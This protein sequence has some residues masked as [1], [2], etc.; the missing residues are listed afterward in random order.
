LS[1]LND[2]KDGLESVEDIKRSGRPSTCTNLEMIAKV[3][4]VILEDRRHT[5][6][7]FVIALG[8][9]MGHGNTF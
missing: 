5:T 1:I 8:C 7:I 9:H 3:R 6:R 4:E 2:F